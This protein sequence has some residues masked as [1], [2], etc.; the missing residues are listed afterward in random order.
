MKNC[1]FHI[2]MHIEED[3]VTG[4]A[5]RPRNMLKAFR[6]IGYDVDIVMGYGKER[7]QQIREIKLKIENGKKYEFLYSE[8]STMPTLLT[9]E[10]HVPRYPFL[11]FSFFSFCKEKGIKIGLFYRDIYWRFPIYKEQVGRLKRM[12]AYPL[13]QH[14]LRKYR[15]LLNICYVPSIKFAERVGVPLNY[16]ELPSGGVLD[17]CVLGKKKNILANR[18]NLHSMRIFYV[19]GITGINDISGLF[20]VVA[21]NDFLELVVCCREEEWEMYGTKYEEYLCARVKIIHESG[22]KLKEYYLNADIASLY[23]HNDQ[24]RD[25]AMPVKLFEYIGYGVP[26]IATKGTAAEE[27]ISRN[28]LG[29]AVDDDEKQVSMLLKHLY[30]NYKEV[31]LK[32]RNCI[33][34][35]YENSW[36]ARAKQVASDLKNDGEGSNNGVHI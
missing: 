34:C 2:P 29:W 23:Y 21:K 5:V 17:H 9:E 30:N 31:K 26:V 4:A 10:D 8:S 25:F 22:D 13:Y 6:T 35:A 36:E 11:D 1:I 16:K 12:I 19:G 7:K 33:N 14:D 20:N 27:Y 28:N 18:D 24:Y 15:K 32:A 3:K